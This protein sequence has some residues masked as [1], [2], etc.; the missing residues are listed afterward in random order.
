MEDK[1]HQSSDNHIIPMTSVSADKGRE[2]KPDIYYYTNQIVNLIFVGKP[3][4]GKWVLIDAGMPKSGKQ[5][6]AAAEERFGKGSKPEAILLTHGHFDHVGSIVH[7]LEEWKGV[8]VYAHVMEFPF[9]TGE[10]AYPD[11]DPTVE[12]GM[13]AKISSIYPHEP[14][15]I[16]PALLPLPMDGSV[17]N[18][19]DWKWIHTP[20]HSP[21]HVSFFRESDRT[22][23]VGDAFV[24]V[25][26]DSFY[27]VLVQK[28]EVN[29]PPPYLTTEWPAA[30]ESVIKLD[31]LN[32]HLV[33]TGHG[34]HMEGEELQKGLNKLAT[35]FDELALP[36]HGKYVEGDES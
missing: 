29:G 17:P 22:L 5:I 36:S 21:G 23:M 12:G 3:E 20:G 13:L 2:V 11:P 15:D 32:P 1:M 33:I 6:I 31:R 7:L 8:P 27:K 24:T 30:K 19:P 28:E 18:L 16:T 35:H 34:T 9:L 26:Q 14:I 4:S 10:L 25:Q